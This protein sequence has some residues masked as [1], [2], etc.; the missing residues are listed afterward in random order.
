MTDPASVFPSLKM[1]ADLDLDEVSSSKWKENLQR[2]A[3]LLISGGTVLLREA[4][5]MHDFHIFT[6]IS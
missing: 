4:F 1:D 2:P 6:V 3:R 5:D